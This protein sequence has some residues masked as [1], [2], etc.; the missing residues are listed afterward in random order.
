MSDSD[1]PLVHEHVAPEDPEGAPGI[2]LLHGRGSHERDL[3]GLADS[4]P[5]GIHVLSAR[6]P[7][8]MGQGFTWYE[9]DLSGGGLEHSQPDGDDWER[10]RELVDA[11][12]DRAK[13]V[14]GVGDLGILGFSQGSILGMGSLLDSPERYAYV[15]G[16]HGYL[17]ARYESGYDVSGKPVFLAGGEQDQIIPE[18][19]TA[20]AAERLRAFGADVT[21]NTYPTGHGIATEEG[22][23]AT[24]WLAERVA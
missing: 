2:L 9:L 7:D 3:L 21:Y 18:H 20:D 23:D 16:L 14:Y 5:D 22:R 10:S 11:F 24:E 8:P 6:A 17:P 12:S 4:F 13:S 15:V 1:F 19:R